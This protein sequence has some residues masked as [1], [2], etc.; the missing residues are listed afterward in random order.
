MLDDR[1]DPAYH[2][3]R[4][5]L[6]YSALS[7]AKYDITKLGQITHTVFQGIGKN[8]TEN[9]KITLLKV[10]NITRSGEIDYS[11]TEFVKDVPEGKLLRN[12]DIVSPF[13]GEAV[14]QCKFAVFDRESGTFAVDNNTGVIR[15]DSEIANNRYVAG[16]LNSSVGKLQLE[17]LIGGGGVPFLGAA[18]ATKLQIPLPPLRIQKQI[19]DKIGSSREQV[20]T[21]RAQATEV[22]KNVQKQVEQMTLVD[23]GG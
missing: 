18:N 2:S 12:G 13:I 19:A 9:P 20:R 7:E 23:H 21:L 17:Q 22:L 10:K 1:L 15:I 6:F 14:R 5:K 4:F 16:V 11:K 8:E 3:T